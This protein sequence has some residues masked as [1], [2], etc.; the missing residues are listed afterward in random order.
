V[1][2]LWN[3]TARAL[4][5]MLARATGISRAVLRQHLRLSFDKVIEYQARGLIHVHTVIRAD[6]PDGACHDPPPWASKTCSA[7]RYSR[8]PERLASPC[9]TPTTPP[10]AHPG[11]G[12]PGRPAY[13]APRH[14]RG[15]DRSE[16]A[17]YIAKYASKATEDV[18]GI[19]VRIRRATDLDDCHVTPHGR[20]LLTARW[21]LGH[22]DEYADL[23]LAR[24]AHQ[25]GYRGHFS[26]W[27][28]RWGATLTQRRQQ[29]QAWH[30]NQ[31][32]LAGGQVIVLSEW[33][34]AG[35]GEPP[36]PP[37]P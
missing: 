26:T 21:H 16:V 22:R 32:N 14:R 18:G 15:T 9:P 20:R 3:Q 17:A 19:P 31:N 24:W 30:D 6:G 11:L 25:Y 34:Y 10:A 29:R 33:H 2:T 5:Q 7:T 37:R 35:T 12:P 1:P 4:P 28:R 27:S 23:R 36:D 13:R 8:R